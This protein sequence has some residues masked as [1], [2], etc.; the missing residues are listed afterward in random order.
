MPSGHERPAVLPSAPMTL[1]PTLAALLLAVACVR[2]APP[3]AAPARPR[4]PSM[5]VM[6]PIV[7]ELARETA[8][9]RALAFT[10]EVP[11][12]V[13]TQAEVLAH[14][15]EERAAASKPG[16][17]EVMESR[18]A[19]ALGLVPDG[20]D[21]HDAI[22]RLVG[23]EAQGYYDPDEGVLVLTEHEAA[24]LPSLGPAGIEARA[25]VVHELTHALQHQHFPGRVLAGRVRPPD[26]SDAARARLALLEGDATVVAMEWAARR[27]AH[28]LLGTAE[29]V[30]RVERWAEGAQVL[31][32]ADVPTWLAA[33]AE[34][35][36][37]LGAVGVAR[38]YTLGAWGRVNEALGD[39]SLR[40]ASVLH[41]EREGVAFVAVDPPRDEALEAA[42]MRRVETRA[43][44][45]VELL[46]LLERGMRRERAAALAASWRGDGF[47]LYEGGGRVAARWAVSLARAED[48]ADVRARLA[49]TVA[50]LG[51]E[52]CP[53]VVG[54]T[55]SRCPVS[56]DAAGERLELRRGW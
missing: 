46:L 15:R 43:L 53:S 49:A 11:L 35:P 20:V 10:R 21:L 37:E 33:A 34:V 32:E 23:A 2:A 38:M 5:A 36:Y 28:P 8:A 22:A 4:V 56:L 50:R 13:E 7:R 18:V 55:A 3:A 26:L 17:A 29:L 14:Q 31:T 16:D 39:A 25:T 54:G 24:A 40:T 45:E 19:T 9:I 1:R 30:P 51:R 12:R 6:L 48:A 47:S 27:R 52:G 41:P 44:G 42:G